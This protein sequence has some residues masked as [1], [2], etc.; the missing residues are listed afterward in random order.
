MKAAGASPPTAGASARVARAR[1]VLATVPD[2]EIPVL[3]VLDLGIVREV[4]ETADGTLR[5]AVSPTYCG[6]PAT[7]VIRAD[8]AAALA[9]A[10]LA[11]VRVVDVLSPPWSSAWIT[12]DGRRKLHRHGIAP[13]T[14]VPGEAAGTECPRCGSLDTE[15]ISEFGSTPCKALHRCRACREP[16]ER[17]KCI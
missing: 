13:P 8:I 12:A 7:T 5:V 10:G 2:P 17:F 3:S 4:E 1:A 9:S 16:F 6:C 15:L 14:S 11:P